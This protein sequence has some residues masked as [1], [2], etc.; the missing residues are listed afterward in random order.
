MSDQDYNE[1]YSTVEEIVSG[2]LGFLAALGVIAI[3]GVL[4]Y[5]WGLYI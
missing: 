3:A 4:G 1:P 5:F 2:I